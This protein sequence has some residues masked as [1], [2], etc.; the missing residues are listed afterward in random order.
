MIIY[1]GLFVCLFVG[2]LQSRTSM[3]FLNVHTKQFILI[4]SNV[5]HYYNPTFNHGAVVL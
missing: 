3:K 2:P 4:I 1:F 5:F